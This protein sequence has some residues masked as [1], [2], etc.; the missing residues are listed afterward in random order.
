MISDVADFFTKGCGR[1][2]RFDTPDCSALRWA[3]A[4]AALRQVCLA[5]GLAEDLRWGHPCY[6]HAGRNIA[7]LG[8]TKDGVRLGLTEAALLDDP[9]ALLTPAGPNTRQADTLR[10]T[11]PEAV[12]RLA[13]ALGDL[14]A[15]AMRH[16]EAGVKA[17]KP[18]HAL[19]LP[20]ELI[21]AL[22]ADPAL[23]EAFHAL[24]PGRQRSHVL[25][26][27][28]A[29]APATRRVRIERLRPRILAGKGATEL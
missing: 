4:V 3:E 19:D 5:A 6:R 17:P 10:V 24:T 18:A 27:A 15:Q 23:A 7:V 20:D 25:A 14:L 1:C 29:K 16:A 28:S 2:A 11:S 8:A 9:Q 12:A 26:L 21:E 22:D 13:A